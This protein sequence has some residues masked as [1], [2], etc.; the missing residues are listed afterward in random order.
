[1]KCTD[2]AFRL[3]GRAVLSQ[4]GESYY[5]YLPGHERQAPSQE[6]F[7]DADRVAAL[8]AQIGEEHVVV[9]RELMA[10]ALRCSMYGD[11][12]WDEEGTDFSAECQLIRAR[13][14]AE[15]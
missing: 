1:M 7:C 11:A 12:C 14:E 15:G 10:Y 5:C 8:A 2:C 4:D 13:L 9:S 6:C 3:Q